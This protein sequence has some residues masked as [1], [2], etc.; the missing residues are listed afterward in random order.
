M[1]PA[2]V[3]SGGRML[4]CQRREP[5]GLGY[6]DVAFSLGGRQPATQAV[7]LGQGTGEQPCT[8]LTVLTLIVGIRFSHFRRSTCPYVRKQGVSSNP[9]VRKRGSGQFPYVRPGGR[10]RR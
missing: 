7:R 2:A 6:S 5:L 1:A 8:P 4:A 9:Y 10:T 3:D